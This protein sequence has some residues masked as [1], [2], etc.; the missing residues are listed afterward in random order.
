MAI[1]LKLRTKGSEGEWV[2]LF[3]PVSVASI[4]EA[5]KNTKFQKELVEWMLEELHTGT[6]FCLRE[7]SGSSS[8]GSR[9]SALLGD[10]DD[11]TEAEAP[12][13][14]RTRKRK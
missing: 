12:V 4:E 2:D 10:S 13:R 5:R 7:T 6:T 3:A 1:T 9:L 8:H 11:A 14:T